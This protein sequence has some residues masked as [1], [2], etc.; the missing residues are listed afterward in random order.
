M[1][2]LADAGAWGLA[3]AMLAAIASFALAVVATFFARARR[4]REP[5]WWAGHNALAPFD[6]YL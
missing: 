3:W 4:E 2:G 5:D 1:G 6:L